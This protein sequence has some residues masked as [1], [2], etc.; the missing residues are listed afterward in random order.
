MVSTA[1]IR[2]HQHARIFVQEAGAKFPRTLS[3]NLPLDNATEIT[4]L[5]STNTARSHVT[6]AQGRQHQ[7]QQQHRNHRVH[8]RTFAQ[9][10]DAAFLRAISVRMPLGNATDC[11]LLYLTNIVRNHVENAKIVWETLS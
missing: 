9:E 6:Y 11:I 2:Q 8:V 7:R 5:I 3:V 1:R 10:M 4:S